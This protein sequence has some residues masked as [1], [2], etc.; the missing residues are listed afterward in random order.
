MICK[1]L[2]FSL[3]AFGGNFSPKELFYQ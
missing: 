2:T 1:P 3:L